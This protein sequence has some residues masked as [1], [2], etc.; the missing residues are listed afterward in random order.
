[1]NALKHSVNLLSRFFHIGILSG[2]LATS[3]ADDRLVGI[4]ILD[5]GFQTTEYLF[6]SDGKY[7]IDRKSADSEFGFSSSDH[8]TYEVV[9]QTL[10]LWPY[11]Y[12]GD[13]SSQAYQFDIN[14]NALE[15]T[16][17]DL[18]IVQTYVF[19]IGSREDVLVREK[20]KGDVIGIWE[21]SITFAGKEEYTFRP[22][23]YYVLKSSSENDQ[24]PPQF[25]RGRYALNASVLTI[26]PYGGSAKEYEVDFFGDDL[27]L[28]DSSGTFGRAE[29]FRK[30]AGSEPLVRAKSAEAEAFLSRT[31]WQVGTWEVRDAVHTVDLT[32][33]PDGHYSAKEDTEFLAGLVR[34]RYALQDRT[35]RLLPFVGQG[36]YAKSNG[37]FGKVE[38]ERELDFYDGELQFI[39]LTSFSQSITIARKR[40]G[41]DAPVLEKVH[42]AQAE[43]ATS[44]WYVGVW[45]VNDPDGWMQFTFR[46]D[47]RYIAKSGTAGAPSEVERGEYRV[48]TDKVTL[49]PYSGLGA[50]RGFELDLYDGDLFLIGDLNRMV[51]ARKVPSSQVEVIQ[52]TTDPVAL[53]G[54]RGSVLGLWTA[55]TPGQSAELVFR[56]DGQFRLKR[57][58]GGFVSQDY[59]LYSADMAARTLIYD[60]R[61]VL[62][63]TLGMDFYGNTL[64]IYGGVNAPSTYV[65]NLGSVDASISQS[66]AADTAEALIDGQWL[67][68]IP[69]ARRNPNAVQVP[70][71]DIP[72]DP[73]PTRIFPDATVF[74]GYQLYRR[75]IASSVVFNENGTLKSWP[76]VNTREW[77]FLPTGRVMVRFKNHLA[78]VTYPETIEDVTTSWGAYRIAPPSGQQDILHIYAENLLFVEMDN[79]DQAEMTLEDGRRNLFWSKDYQIQ[80]EWASE[81]KPVTCQSPTNP[82]ASL[83]NT[84]VAL[85]TNIPPD[86]I[87]SAQAARIHITSSPS[88][89]IG[90]HGTSEI[91]A[92]IILERA[93]NLKEPVTWQSFQTNQ[94]SA[95]A[96]TWPMSPE[97]QGA[98]FFRVRIERN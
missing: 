33:R 49:A 84:G 65:V 8:G 41:S 35:I 91:A 85:R 40:D 94:V 88:G 61:F 11:D 6:R 53:K 95:G 16:Q 29:T 60:S 31:N 13:P 62:A 75:L 79:G 90:I 66:F 21:R 10:V 18:Q 55:N 81:Q 45:E 25:I 27:T 22:G 57:C 89:V 39:D 28:I 38:R 87:G 82:D 5:E 98:R 3:L 46:P 72:S 1:M 52:K 17:A 14:G 42:Q 69:I 70:T 68:R 12:L 47:G 51:V 48:A 67:N 19:K 2:I 54:E 36:L 50:A 44:G 9:G 23:G 37:E 64:T 32:F 58:S 71:G 7:Q 97:G 26:H 56:D 83:M 76:V 77:H 4:W 30:V 24:F 63:Q 59:G 73:F 96:F 80:W 34:G 78:G 93:T 92:K 74:G 86:P 43:R 20:A 15:L